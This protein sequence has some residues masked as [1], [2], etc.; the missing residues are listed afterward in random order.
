MTLHAHVGG[1]PPIAG[2]AA[3]IFDYLGSSNEVW[4]ATHAEVAEYL[5]AYKGKKP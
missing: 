2:M 4:I 5:L 3:Q 1:R